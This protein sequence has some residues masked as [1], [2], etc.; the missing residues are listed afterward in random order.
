MQ[1]FCYLIRD[2]ILAFSFLVSPHFPPPIL[3]TPSPR[4]IAGEKT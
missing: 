3:R 2:G 4:H 1:G